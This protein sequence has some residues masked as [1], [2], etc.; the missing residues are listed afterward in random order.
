MLIISKWPGVRL[1]TSPSSAS[2][3]HRKCGSLDVSQSYGPPWPVTGI[4][5]PVPSGVLSRNTIIWVPNFQGI[6]KD[7]LSVSGVASGARMMN[8]KGLGRK[9]SWPNRGIIPVFAC[10]ESKT[11]K[12]N[13]N[14]SADIRTE[15]LPSTSPKCYI[16]SNCCLV[17]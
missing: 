15:H 5:L 9:L 17:W 4:A 14:I 3:L 7:S 11:K 13:T 6:L 16:Y 2:R 8:V 12:K 10:R 1:R